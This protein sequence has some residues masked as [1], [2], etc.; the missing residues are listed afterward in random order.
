MTALVINTENEMRKVAYDPPHYE[1]IREAVGGHYELVRP[2]GLRKPYCMM[3]NEEGRLLGLP[4]NPLACYLYGTLIHG[5]P[6]V[7]DVMILTL[8][9]Y[10][11]EPDAV[12]MSDDEAQHLGDNFVRMSA[13]VVHWADEERRST[14]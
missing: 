13:G 4:L 8:G 1:V 2:E 10:A 6:I 7:G 9:Y 12:G 3:V 11:G 5:S 14:L